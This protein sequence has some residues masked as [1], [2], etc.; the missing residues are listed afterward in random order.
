MPFPSNYP[1]FDGRPEGAGG[2]VSGREPDGAVTGGSAGAGVLSQMVRVCHKDAGEDACVSLCAR[3]QNRLTPSLR[4]HRHGGIHEI[5]VQGVGNAWFVG[6]VS[7]MAS[8]VQKYVSHG[9]KGTCQVC[10]VQIRKQV[11]QESSQ[12]QPSRMSGCLE[13]PWEAC[14]TSFQ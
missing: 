4:E 5:S 11:Q 10:R 2:T 7:G 9:V 8:L 3:R 12:D 6:D 1:N 13:G 14:C